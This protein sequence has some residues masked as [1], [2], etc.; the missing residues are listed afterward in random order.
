MS[1][2]R[3]QCRIL[4]LEENTFLHTGNDVPARDILEP[5]LRSVIEVETH[6]WSVTST[7]T[8]NRHPH[9]NSARRRPIFPWAQERMRGRTTDETLS[10]NRPVSLHRLASCQEQGLAVLMKL[11]SGVCYAS[12][13]PRRVPE[14]PAFRPLKVPGP[15]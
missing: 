12:M 10:V 4:V 14:L 1:A 2:K 3:T 6:Q 5:P 9:L 8:P 11:C 15:I 13:A 7:R